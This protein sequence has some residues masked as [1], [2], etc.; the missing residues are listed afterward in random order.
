MSVA[1]RPLSYLPEGTSFSRYVMAKALARGDSFRAQMH[2]DRW[3]DTPQV[4]ACL[5]DELHAK[6]A[7]A[8][9]STTDATWA[10]PLAVH[11][12]AREALTLI[13]GASILGALENKFRRVPFR[14]SVA[15][16]TGAGTGGA[17]IGEGLATPVAA[18]AFDTLSQE[19]YKAGKIVVLSQ[20]LLQLSNPSA[21]KTIRETVANG[22]AAFLDEQLLTNTVTLSANLRPAAITNAATAV[23]QTGSTA[24]A[25]QTDLAALLAAITTGGGSLVWIMRPKTAYTI[26]ATIGAAGADIPRTLFGIPLVLSAN[27][28]QQITLVDAACVLYSDDNGIEIDTSHE[29][30]I[31]MD[32]APAEPT[33]ASTVLESLFQK[34]RWAVRVTRW[35]AYLRAQT[36]SVAYMTVTY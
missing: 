34:N 1:T 15:R 24:A 7:I 31:Q 28:P 12:I 20:E 30:L 25:M 27:S 3:R 14:T 5:E 22:V 4:K 10:G 17:W 6:A 33:A 18:T 32:S 36:G 8:A 19:A 11:G 26:A 2:A 21:E 16:E 13:R 23:A 35:I 29:A 9:G